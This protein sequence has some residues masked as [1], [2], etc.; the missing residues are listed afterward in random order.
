MVIAYD[1]AIGFGIGFLHKPDPTVLVEDL[2]ILKPYAVAL[3][4][5]ILTRFEAGIKNALD[6]STVQRNVANTILDS[7]SA[8]FTAKRW[9]R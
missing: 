7:K 2:K 1:L 6:K 9:S 8:R 4:P 5:R 3:V